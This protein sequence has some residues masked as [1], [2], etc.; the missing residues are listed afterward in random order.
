MTRNGYHSMGVGKLFHNSKEDDQ[1]LFDSGR[2]DGNWYRYQNIEQGFLNS[3]TTPDAY[4]PDD[5]F[6][7]YEIASRGIAG[8][9]YLQSKVQEGKKENW[10]LAIGFKQPHTWYHMPK[11]YFDMYKGS[12]LFDRLDDRDRFFPNNTPSIGYRCCALE[13][14]SYMN[15]EG[16]LPSR[17]HEVPRFAMKVRD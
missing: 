3:S 8:F 11:K 9:S 16:R 1:S 7:D 6:R 14:I 10:L 2:W 5:F 13:R 4:H 15:E 12:R 17:E